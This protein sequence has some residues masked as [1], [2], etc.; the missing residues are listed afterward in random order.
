MNS[1]PHILNVTFRGTDGKAL[2]L[3]LDRNGIAVSAGAACA[4]G[5]PEPSHV[6]LSMG[7]TRRDAMGSIRFSLSEFTTQEEIDSVCSVLPDLVNR[8]AF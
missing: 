7:L 5:S 1:L 3:L 6:L 4:A 2:L 8:A